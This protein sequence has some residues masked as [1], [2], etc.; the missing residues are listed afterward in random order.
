MSTTEI[1][2]LLE[3]YRQAAQLIEAA[4]AEQEAIKAAL[5]AE[6]DARG[7]DRL[8]GGILKATRKTVT[9]ARLDGKALRAAAPDLVA[10]YTKTTT[11]SRFA[12]Q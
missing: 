5:L 4:Q 1:T 6:M 10:Q 3:D 9:S 2:A 8:D 11:Y 12:V 7:V